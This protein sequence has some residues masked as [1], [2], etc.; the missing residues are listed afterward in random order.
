M[1]GI[2]KNIEEYNPNKNRKILIVFDNM[3][4]DMI[5]N[6][7][8]NKV[9]TELSIRERKFRYFAVQIDIRLN[10]TTY[11]LIEIANKRELKQVSHNHLSDIDFKYFMNLKEKCTA[12]PYSFLFNDATLAL[13]N[14]FSLYDE[15]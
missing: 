4:G 13:D 14:F 3:I 8:L 12:K 7:K 15:K 6:K 10:S 2:Y 11:F 1:D 5:N 9:V